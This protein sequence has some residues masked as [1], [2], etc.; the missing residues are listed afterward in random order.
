MFL[1]SLKLWINELKLNIMKCLNRYN[2]K[3]IHSPR[4]YP[5][6]MYIQITVPSASF[7][8]VEHKFSFHT[9]KVYC[10]SFVVKR[11]FSW[12]GWDSWSNY[13]LA[14]VRLKQY[15]QKMGAGVIIRK[16]I[17]CLNFELSSSH[18]ANYDN[19]CCSKTKGPPF[20]CPFKLL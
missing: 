16:I 10:K 11:L 14:V 17:F 20:I 7:L 8:Q 12:K 13:C 9:W 18:F 1:Q 4:I 19:G 15:L 2:M 3:L 6:C 5:A